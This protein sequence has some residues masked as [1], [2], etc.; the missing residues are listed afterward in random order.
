MG[1]SLATNPP[2]R[3]VAAQVYIALCVASLTVAAPQLNFAG[4]RSVSTT[5]GVVTS[6]NINQEKVVTDVVTALQPSIA[7]A[8]A[9]A[10]A[11]FQTSTLALPPATTSLAIQGPTQQ[12]ASANAAAAA[13]AASAAV[14]PTAKPEYNFEY[15]V[16]DNDEQ[17]Y[18][19]KS[20]ERDGDT[21]TGTYSYVDPDGSLITVNYQAG[22]MGY[23]Q[24]SEA[25]EGFVTINAKPAKA[26][27][28]TSSTSTASGSST[29]SGSRFSGATS[30]TSL[31]SNSGFASTASSSSIDQSALI[32]QIIAA[33]Q[34]QINNAVQSA[35][36]STRTSN[37][38]VGGP[39][40]AVVPPQGRTA[41]V[42]AVDEDL[43]STFGEGF[44][45]KI[46][47][48]EFN[49]AY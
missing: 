13:E 43:S 47:T 42:F 33:L 18:I 36:S 35:I 30:S 27:V 1:I 19:S 14:G 16:A 29:S 7:K 44:S 3:M 20:E 12:I 23:T 45:V 25:Q 17:T 40:V 2:H 22:P 31:T 41:P 34:P 6:T 48:P 15:K 24:T 11:A 38:A 5:R 9:D 21:L 10:L 28:A 39:L 46:D 8:V 32:A 49:I 26:S 37:S 4:P